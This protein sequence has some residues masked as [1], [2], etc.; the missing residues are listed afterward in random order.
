MVWVS[1]KLLRV[2]KIFEVPLIKIIDGIRPV[3]PQKIT[4]GLFT[5]GVPFEPDD[6]GPESRA[7]LPRV[8]LSRETKRS[9]RVVS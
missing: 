7:T 1:G 3:R 2:I 4:D 5:D 6:T 9:R 8:N